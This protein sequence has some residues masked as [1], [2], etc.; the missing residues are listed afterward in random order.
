MAIDESRV[1]DGK[2]GGAARP[3]PDRGVTTGVTDSYGA[4]LQQGF[5]KITGGNGGGN[6]VIP[7]KPRMEGC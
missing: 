5:D 2:M 4:N 1:S 7:G 3:M 6:L